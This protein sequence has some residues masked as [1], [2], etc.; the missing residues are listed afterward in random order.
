[1]LFPVSIWGTVWSG[2]GACL[3]GGGVLIAGLV[4]WRDSNISRAAQAKKIHAALVDP[5]AFDRSQVRI[6]NYSEERIS[7][8]GVELTRPKLSELDPAVF[9]AA[10]E[11]PTD[12]E[13]K[14]I[15]DLI[16]QT[17]IYHRYRD[18]ESWS[19]GAGENGCIQLPVPQPFQIISVFFRDRRGRAWRIYNIRA[20]RPKLIR[21]TDD[22]IFPYRG[23]F[24]LLAH[25]SA[26]LKRLR[27]MRRV[28]RW[29]RNDKADRSRAIE[30][31]ITDHQRSALRPGAGDDRDQMP[32]DDDRK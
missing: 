27:F 14:A 6:E 25:P 16:H 10:A 32:Q 24:D 30:E 8:I 3:T 26:R 13:I 9:E 29:E 5:Y 12:A 22:L 23:R 17:S 20:E 4:Y 11:L 21:V 7:E 31:L 15:Q 1:M 28:R 18:D 19:L 2:V